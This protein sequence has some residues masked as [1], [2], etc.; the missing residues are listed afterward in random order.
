MWDD[1]A[2]SDEGKSSGGAARS[3]FARIHNEIRRRICLLDYAPGMKLSEEALAEEFGTSRTPLRRVLARLEDEGLVKSVHGVGTFV[4]DADIG[5]LTQVYRLR[6]ELVELL[7]KLDPQRPDPDLMDTFRSLA[8]RSRTMLAEGHPRE[9]M[10]LD[11]D[12]FQ[13]L[14]QLTSNQPLREICERLYYRTNRIWVKMG[15]AARID[16][17]EEFT[18]FNREVGDVVSA[19]EIGDLEAVAH[20]HRAHISMSFTRLRIAGKQEGDAPN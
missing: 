16:L 20:I 17:K 7:A 14:M 12:L 1:F 10:Q 9:F 18:I 13:A 3:R 6:L 4:T 5:E 11:M 19:L 15:L 8:A 2:A